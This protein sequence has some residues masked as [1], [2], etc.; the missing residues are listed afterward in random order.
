VFDPD[1]FETTV[2][3]GIRVMT[4]DPGAPDCGLSGASLVL[5][6]GS[7]PDWGPAPVDA[8]TEGV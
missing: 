5:P 3:E 1:T 6:G 4:V 2:G 8:T 7:Q